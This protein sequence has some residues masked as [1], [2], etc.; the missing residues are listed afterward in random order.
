MYRAL[1]RIYR[2]HLRMYKA[3]LRM[4]TALLR[5]CTALLRT[6]R[7]HLQMYVILPE[8]RISARRPL[9]ASALDISA[10]EPY[11]SAKE[12]YTSIC[13]SF[14]PSPAY[15]QEDPLCVCPYTF[16]NEESCH[17]YQGVIQSGED[18]KDVLSCR[19]LFANEPLIIGFFCGKWPIE[20]RQPMHL[21]H[22]VSR[23]WLSHLIMHESCHTCEGVMSHIWRSHVT[24]LNESCHTSEWVTSFYPSPAYPLEDPCMCVSLYIHKWEVMSHI[25]RSHVPHLKESCHTSEGVM[26]HIWMSRLIMPE[27]CTSAPLYVRVP[28]HPQMSSINPQKSPIYPLPANKTPYI[29]KKSPVNPQIRSQSKNKKSPIYRQ[30]NPI[31]SAGY[32]GF[33]C[34]YPEISITKSPVHPQMSRIFP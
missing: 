7:A 15:L 21:R 10:K 30:K 8:S 23:I 16:A 24:H 4:C 19:S 18:A 29:L 17:T 6:Y 31:Y 13:M 25:S 5:M 12:P 1:S 26:S 33:F 2:A 20:I 14:C 32:I 34:K 3:L 9:Y 22:P 28:I 27:S 11:T